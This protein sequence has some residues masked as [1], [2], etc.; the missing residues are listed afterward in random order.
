[1]VR[2]LE[3]KHGDRAFL[4]MDDK[5]F[6]LIVNYAPQKG[7]HAEQRRTLVHRV[8]TEEVALDTARVLTGMVWRVV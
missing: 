4:D 7:A 8:P 5:G 3:N 2:Q 1:M 6:I